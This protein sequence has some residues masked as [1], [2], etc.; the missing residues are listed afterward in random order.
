VLIL[1]FGDAKSIYSTFY[2]DN[3]CKE[4]PRTNDSLLLVNYEHFSSHVSI[5]FP[6]PNPIAVI[7][8]AADTCVV[9]VYEEDP[10]CLS[11]IAVYT[12]GRLLVLPWRKIHTTTIG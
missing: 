3:A 6:I 9:M 4:G 11:A 1:V 7:A 5:G 2:S 8:S 12:N 10:K